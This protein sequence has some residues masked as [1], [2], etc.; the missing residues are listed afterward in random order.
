M[1]QVPPSVLS[2]LQARTADIRNMCV[3]AHVDHG[4]TTLSDT[5]IASNGIISP[6]LSGH[7]RYLDYREDEQLRCITM[8]ASAISL[9]HKRPDGKEH[10]INLVDS[11]GHFDFSGEVSAAVRV[12]DGALVL[13]DALEGVCVQTQAVL[14]Q[15]WSEKLG[16]CLVFTKIDRLILELHMDP[17]EAYL[18]LR[19]LLEQ[20]NAL[21]GMLMSE[22]A[23]REGRDARTAA[24]AA[25]G[26]SDD[27]DEAAE[28][29]E[30]TEDACDDTAFF[31]PVRGNVAFASP[32]DGWAFRIEQFAKIYAA[33]LGVKED[34]LKHT[35][36]GEYY[37]DGRSKRVFT[38]PVQRGQQP[39]FVQAV[40]KPVWEVYT[41]AAITP[42][43]ERIKKIVAALK[44]NATPKELGSSDPKVVVMAIM[45]KWVPVAPCVLDMIVDHLPS[46]LEAQRNRAALLW[47]SAAITSSLL[48]P[49]AVAEQ[50]EI[51]RCLRECSALDSD[52]VVLYV[53]KMFAMGKEN[54]VSRH[55]VVQHIAVP[56]PRRDPNAPKPEP[57]AAA[58]SVAVAQPAQ[59]QEQDNFIAV[60]RIFCGVIRRGKP[61][62]VLAPRYEPSRPEEHSHPFVAE[63]LYL[64]M[65]QALEDVEGVPAGNIL[66]IG[67]LGGLIIKTATLS[68][69]L[70]CPA[71]RPLW[72]V[73]A[74]PI[75]R[76]AVE[77][78]NAS[79]MTAL[80]RGM[81]LLNQADPVVRTFV[82]ESGEHVILAAGELHLERCLKDL[83]ELFAKVEVVAS[84]PMVPLRETLASSPN[85]WSSGKSLEFS[86][87]NKSAVLRI[88][89]VPLPPQISRAVEENAKIVAAAY[90]RGN[91]S[92]SVDEES[93]Q[94]I[95]VQVDAFRER[96]K[97]LFAESGPHALALFDKIWSFGPRQVG[98]NILFNCSS[99]HAEAMSA[100]EA[101]EAAAVAVAGVED[102]DE[103]ERQHVHCPDAQD[104]R[105]AT[106]EDL[107]SS[108]IAGF[109]M[110]CAGGPLCSEPLYGVGFI[111]EDFRFV[112]DAGQA[113]H[114]AL[115]PM[116]GQVIGTMRSGCHAAFE[117]GPVRIMEPVYRCEVQVSSD[118]LGKMYTVLHRRRAKVM[119]EEMCDGNS[120]LFSIASHLPV[121]ESFG[122]A[123]EI[124]KKTSGSACPQL[125]FDR[126]V[127]IDQDPYFV[128]T[129]A[130]ELEEYGEGA[131]GGIPPNIPLKFIEQTRKRKGLPVSEKL[132]ISAE[133]QRTLSKK[134]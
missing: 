120:S 33:K 44:I 37:L 98:P 26:A 76:V 51:L 35:L 73:N 31:S 13:V 84:E 133:K 10:L 94:Q 28:A 101:A 8:K 21:V 78:K 56:G 54:C 12:T 4:K 71:L 129:T 127:L 130:E 45:S 128:P 38:K 81:K 18:H 131:G 93:R 49:E 92:T 34:I 115:G 55:R 125:E 66:G 40:L 48:S 16:M 41:S 25:T 86:T 30:V 79:D 64:L 122:F 96:L 14:R 17:Y 90:V 5:L 102:E 63:K 107:S 116:S 53:A 2:S 67:G 60:A 6:K 72:S 42:D 95:A 103:R 23:I 106:L 75:V 20:M 50:K 91:A 22:E 9:L 62:Y 87:P 70:A 80:V 118:M 43:P 83:R 97:G 105:E 3:L 36:W 111:L 29:V 109:Q 47:S 15:A 52:P 59:P 126:Y 132:V 32:I 82:Q 24:A 88:R 74:Q 112:E 110:A 7:V 123:E 19:K 104:S 69:S 89:A 57:T 100:Q 134:K 114:D 68:S 11:P 117:E 119:S 46:P 85:W 121:T 65:G 27:T 124:M 61:L 113:H 108:V 1:P 58:A 99:T 39:L 77:T